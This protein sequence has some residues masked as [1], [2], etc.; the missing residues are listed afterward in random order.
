MRFAI[1]IS[2]GQETG[3]QRW[4]R[5]TPVAA[6][7]LFPLAETREFQDLIDQNDDWKR[8]RHLL[9]IQGA[10]YTGPEIP[11][12]AWAAEG[13]L[14]HEYGHRKSMRKSRKTRTGRRK[15]RRR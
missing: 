12:T 4:K 2:S 9:G 3:D 14:S 11:R 5:R 1:D 7:E 15:Y 8:N 10:R 13:T 6:S